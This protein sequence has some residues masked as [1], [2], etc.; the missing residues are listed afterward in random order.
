MPAR[1][2]NLITRAI[3]DEIVVLDDEHGFVHRLNASA[4]RIWT[5]CDGTRSTRQV[6]EAFAAD[7]DRQPDDV[8]A[9]VV[10]TLADFERLGLLAS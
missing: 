9:D 6:A 10:Q 2:T 4:S 1:R 5:Y 7:V 8:L 3:D